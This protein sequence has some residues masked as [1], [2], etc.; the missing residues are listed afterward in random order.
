MRQQ[1]NTNRKSKLQALGASPLDLLDTEK[2]YPEVLLSIDVV[3]ATS[4]QRLHL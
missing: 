4:S 1:D 3:S 2:N